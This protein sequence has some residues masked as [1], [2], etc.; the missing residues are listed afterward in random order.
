MVIDALIA[1][2]AEL[3]AVDRFARSYEADRTG[4]WSTLIPLTQPAPGHQYRFEV[5]LDTC[6]GC[7]ACVTACHSL[8]GLDVGESFRS[9]GVLLTESVPVEIGPGPVNQTVTTACHHCADP[10]C[11]TGCPANAYEKDPVTGVVKHLDDAC[12]GCEYC[13]LTC[14]YDVPVYNDRL[15]IVRKCDMCTDRLAD[16]E[17]PACVQGCPN[18][19]ITIGVVSLAEV[20]TPGQQGS[21]LPSAPPSILTSP[22]TRY[23]R[24][25][26]DVADT[27]D[28][29]V[30]GDAQHVAPGPGHPPLVVLLV[31]SQAA[32]GLHIASLVSSPWLSAS[33]RAASAL[34]V[35]ALA[36]VAASASVLHLG[37]PF[38]AWRAVLG[39]GH[40]WLSR[41]VVAVGAF[42]TAALA[43]AAVTLLTDSIDSAA[44][45]A[46]GL[47]GALAGAA[48][49]SASAMVYVATKRTWW[50]ASLTGPKF[51]L[52][53]VV[54]GVAM[55]RFVTAVVDGAV[56]EQSFSLA[57]A[58]LIIVS[59]GVKTRAET[60]V[61]LQQLDGQEQRTATLLRGDLSETLRLRLGFIVGAALLAAM[62]ALLSFTG[63]TTLTATL[64]T[65]AA[66]LTAV[67]AIGGELLARSLFFQASCVSVMP[68]GPT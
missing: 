34:I 16:G 30:A 31:L 45:V 50:R 61:L 7:K 25:G 18:N 47:V 49:V 24:S 63:G 48:T 4:Q 32:V 60:L 37:Q 15:G 12:I 3:P 29:A 65:S 21:L 64:T 20:T 41:E 19:A 6:T 35:V 56:S 28:G 33:Q 1:A 38:K 26:S 14:P 51:G 57:L 54:G 11:M 8:N 55:L 27:L 13:T 10:G 23:H 68:G 17:A 46:L 42:A 66:A 53:A 9:V 67:V 2:Q 5:D 62:T 40:S 22:S 58:L 43:T 44:G 59:L 39:F 52:T 36:L